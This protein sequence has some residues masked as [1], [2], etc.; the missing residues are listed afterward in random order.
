M[1]KYSSIKKYGKKLYPTLAKR[2]GEQDFYSASQIRSTIYQ[3][4]YNP[5]YLPIGYLLFLDKTVLTQVIKQ[6]FPQLCLVNYKNELCN[7]LNGR[8]HYGFLQ[9]LSQP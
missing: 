9:L 6:E 5:K 7:Y 2:Y 3:C 8:E 4:D 1:F